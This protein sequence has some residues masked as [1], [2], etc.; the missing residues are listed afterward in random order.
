M[1]AESTWL[2]ATYEAIPP[3]GL[4]YEIRS[5]ITPEPPIFFVRMANGG[6]RLYLPPEGRSYAEMTNV[7]RQLRPFVPCNKPPD[8]RS[9]HVL[10]ATSDDLSRWFPN[11]AAMIYGRSDRREPS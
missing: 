9:V 10:A 3:F 1:T 2:C 6:T 11:L 8:D 5:S 7:N 4:L